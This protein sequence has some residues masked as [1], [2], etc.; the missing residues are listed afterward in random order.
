MQNT[1]KK[2]DLV[3]MTYHAPVRTATG[4]DTVSICGQW[5]INKNGEWRPRDASEQSSQQTFS[6]V[7]FCPEVKANVRREKSTVKQVKAGSTKLL[8][9]PSA[10]TVSSSRKQPRN[11]DTKKQPQSIRIQNA[12]CG[13]PPI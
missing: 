7:D 8:S 4:G 5:L 2:N 13:L 11:V 9:R 3:K 1:I 10:K 12:V 6:G